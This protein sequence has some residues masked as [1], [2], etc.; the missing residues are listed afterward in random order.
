MDSTVLNSWR[1]VLALRAGVR[2]FGGQHPIWYDYPNAARVW[3]IG[4]DNPGKILSGEYDGICI[5][6]AEE[7]TESDFETL[8]T[9]VTGRGAITPT[10]MLFGDCNPAGEDH[11]IIQR[12]DAGA[13][14]LLN[15]RHEDNPRLY[16]D[17]GALTE[18]GVTTMSILDRLTGVRYQRL[19]LGRWIGAEGQYYTQLD[20][21][22]HMTTIDQIPPGWPALDYGFSHPLSFGLFTMDDAGLVILCGM[23]HAARWYIAQHAT[24]IA[25]LC[26]SF[27]VSVTGLRVAAGHDCW[28]RGRDDPETIADKFGANGIALERANVARVIG[29][30]AIGERLGNPDC[31]PPLAPSLLFGQRARLAFD[32]LAR[33]VH[34]PTDAEDVRKTNADQSGR[35]G[36]DDYD[37]LRYGVMAAPVRTGGYTTGGARPA[38]SAAERLR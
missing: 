24:A 21:R 25:G 6:Q 18:A 29:A 30:R 3:I 32:A 16:D 1:R 34:D 27:G 14:Q 20:E 7:L 17:A 10:P 19:R 4:L 11:W 23:H 2:P 38:A 37:M 8:S 31:D 22:Q 35:G 5:N 26:E 15:S 36:D 33:M 12:R 9:R 13:L 28:S